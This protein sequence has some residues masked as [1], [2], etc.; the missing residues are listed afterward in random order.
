MGKSIARLKP[1]IRHKLLKMIFL[2]KNNEAFFQIEVSYYTNYSSN[3]NA[4]LV[5]LHV[6]YFFNIK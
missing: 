2:E 4:I 1:M 5:Y 3:R 6:Y